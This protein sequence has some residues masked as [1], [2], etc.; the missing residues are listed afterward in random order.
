MPCIP[1][2]CANTP[3]ALSS[4]TVENNALFFIVEI[5]KSDTKNEFDNE[6]IVH[7]TVIYNLD[8]TLHR[9][10]SY[11]IKDKKMTCFLKGKA[12]GNTVYSLQE[13]IHIYYV[14]S[15]NYQ[16]ISNQHDQ[17]LYMTS[18]RFLEH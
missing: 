9:M 10:S 11:V 2:P 17:L 4:N 14:V 7:K 6:Y 12:V 13:L 1:L 16:N 18:N 3:N 8:D 5:L 15:T